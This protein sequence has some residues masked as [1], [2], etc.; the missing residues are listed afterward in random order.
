M[1]QMMFALKDRRH[2]LLDTRD[3]KITLRS[4]SHIKFIDDIPNYEVY[5]KSPYI[6]GVIYGKWYQPIYK[7]LALKRNLILF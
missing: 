5:T 4:S 7:L 6:R 2:E 3:K 1:L